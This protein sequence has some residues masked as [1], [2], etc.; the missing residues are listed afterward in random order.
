MRSG[1][2]HFSSIIIHLQLPCRQTD[3]ILQGYSSV[4]LIIKNLFFCPFFPGW[5]STF[6]CERSQFTCFQQRSGCVSFTTCWQLYNHEGPIQSWRLPFYAN[7]GQL[8]R[9]REGKIFKRSPSVSE[10]F[11]ISIFPCVRPTLNLNFIT[12]IINNCVNS[13]LTGY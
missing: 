11:Y 1:R 7:S 5:R 9:G 8:T 10:R 3:F 12:Y 13:Y 2:P 4:N 6:R